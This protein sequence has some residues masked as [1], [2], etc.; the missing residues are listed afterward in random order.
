MKVILNADV[1]NIGHI[2][3][4]VN[5]KDGYFRNYLL[6][7]GLA[8]E[9]T[10][11]NVSRLDHEKQRIEAKRKREKG[12]AQDLAKKIEQAQVRIAAKV[13]E[14]EKL[15]GSVTAVMIAE[16][17]AE[18]GIEIDKRKVLLAEPIRT[19]GVFTVAVKVHQ[20]VTANVK[21]WVAAEE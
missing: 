14:E 5:V 11:R 12:E 3:E 18:A 10:T 20:D 15:Y 21:V 9:A 1:P 8:V 19:T 13:G 16:K 6:P 2:G 7:K 17:L 4:V